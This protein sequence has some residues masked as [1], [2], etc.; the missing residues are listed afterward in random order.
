[1]GAEDRETKIHAYLTVSVRAGW[2]A[3]GGREGDGGE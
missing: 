1:M 2:T 3:G